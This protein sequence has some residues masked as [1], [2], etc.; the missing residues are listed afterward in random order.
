MKRN[1]S[2]FTLLFLLIT[3]FVTVAQVRN[4][5]AMKGTWTGQWVNSY[6]SSTGSITVTI[7]VDLVHQTAHGDWNVGGDILGSPKAPFSTDITLTS[8]GF[9]ANFNSSIWG[10]I[11]GT[12]LFTGAY[13][14]SAINCPNPNASKIAA[15][16]TITYLVI[17]GTFTFVWAPAGTSPINGT[18]TIT[19]QNPV[20]DPTN[21]TFLNENPKG[22]IN[23]TWKDNANNETG[24]RIE[25]KTLPSGSWTQIGTVGANVT[26]YAD[27][28]VTSETQYTYRVAAY[29]ASTESEYSQ[30]VTIKTLATSVEDAGSIPSD[31]LLLQNYPNPFN[32]STVI[33]YNLPR[34]S[35]VK[36]SVYTMLGK[37]I[38]V[39]KNGVQSEGQYELR[40]DGSNQASGIYIVKMIAESIESGNKFVDYKK[41]VLIK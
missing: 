6:Y 20:G 1:S 14:G 31:Y 27:N 21:L 2:L 24:F 33:R 17:N 5:S 29:S 30:E 32:P 37:L 11:S 12:G 40:F 7:S 8:T 10:D 19:K 41:M 16:G 22:T 35:K 25:K 38:A 9:T 34:E 36:I 13:S 26:S 15:T 18:V 28:S 3:S 23:L 39:L 4:I